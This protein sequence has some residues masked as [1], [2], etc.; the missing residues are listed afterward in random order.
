M[1]RY[2]NYTISGGINTID[3][4]HNDGITTIQRSHDISVPMHN[5][6]LLQKSDNFFLANLARFHNGIVHAEVYDVG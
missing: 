5:S 1:K 4:Q 3:T 6:T 2:Q